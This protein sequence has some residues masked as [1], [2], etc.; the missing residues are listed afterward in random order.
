MDPNETQAPPKEPYEKPALRTIELI[1]EET[2]L[3]GCKSE[4]GHGGFV[5]T[6]VPMPPGGGCGSLGS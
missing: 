1:A 4:P 2:L 5:Y 6:C 3:T